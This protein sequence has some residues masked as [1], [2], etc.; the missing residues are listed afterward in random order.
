M[1]GNNN[2]QYQFKDPND[3]VIQDE[4]VDNGVPVIHLVEVEN[5]ENQLFNRKLAKK[6]RRF[7]KRVSKRGRKIYDKLDLF[8]DKKFLSECFCEGD[9]EEFYNFYENKMREYND[10]IKLYLAK[11]DPESQNRLEEVKGKKRLLRKKRIFLERYFI[12]GERHQKRFEGY[13]FRR[14]RRRQ[15]MPNN[16]SD[17]KNNKN[18]RVNK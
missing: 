16:W 17:I 2:N 4:G 14:W 9:R 10:Q 5:Q 7:L 6:K 15:I 8:N 12:K 3:V 11:P 1:S 18:K 13:K